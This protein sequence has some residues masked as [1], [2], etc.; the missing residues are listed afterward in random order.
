MA[1]VV[2]VINQLTNQSIKKSTRI[3]SLSRAKETTSF[4]CSKITARFQFN[5]FLKE[6]DT[7]AEGG[8][9]EDMEEVEVMVVVMVMEAIR[10]NK[11]FRL[12]SFF[13]ETYFVTKQSGSDQTNLKKRAKKSC[14]LPWRQWPPLAAFWAALLKPF[15]KGKIILTCVMVPLKSGFFRKEIKGI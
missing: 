14:V 11:C 3:K 9:E 2:E 4:H 7:E 15:L 5:N 10:A 8:M 6:E 12:E 13:K 1:T